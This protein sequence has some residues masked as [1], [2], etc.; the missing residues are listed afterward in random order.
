MPKRAKILLLFVEMCILSLFTASFAVAAP[1]EPADVV[2]HK[3]KECAKMGTGDECV[4]CVPTGDWEI[5]TGE[6]PAGYTQLDDFA[7]NSCTYSGN[8]ISMCDFARKRYSP[9][10][11][12]ATILI[13]GIVLIVLAVL[14]FVVIRKLWRARQ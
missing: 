1:S 13:S 2:N 4:T 10:D 12:N 6:C 3:T 11:T 9:K 14:T 7:P 8:T 5:L